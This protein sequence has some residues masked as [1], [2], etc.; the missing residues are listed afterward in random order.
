LVRALFFTL[1]PYSPRQAE[2]AWYG[3]K[4]REKSLDSHSSRKQS[5]KSEAGEAKITQ[6]ASGRAG[7]SSEWQAEQ[8]KRHKEETALKLAAESGLKQMEA[9]T[10]SV[11]RIGCQKRKKRLCFCISLPLR[12]AVKL[13]PA[14]AAW[15]HVPPPCSYCLS[16][17][18]LAST[19]HRI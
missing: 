9:L 18:I 1:Q 17:R 4:P 19:S 15:W 3:L 14:R 10:G 8:A 6:K 16:F 5:A 2:Q 12:D 13:S 7:S 11:E